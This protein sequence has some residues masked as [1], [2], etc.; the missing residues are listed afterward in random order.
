MEIIG[1]L[2]A[3]LMGL[4]LG[5]LGGGGSILTVPILV[6]VLGIN[7]VLATAYSLF[8]VGT[9]SIIGAIRKGMEGFVHWRTAVIF[10][11]PSLIAVFLT[12]YFLVPA[13]PE[14]IFSIGGL[15]ITKNIMIMIFFALVMLVAS[16]SMLKTS[17]K[18]PEPGAAS[19][20]IPKIIA[21]G[22]IVGVITGLVGAGGGFLIVPALVILLGMPMKQAVG[23]SLVIISIKSLVGFLG[24]IGSGQEIEWN[25][26]LTFT[27]FSMAGMFIGLYLNRFISSTILKKVFGWF[28]VI[29]AI[30]I[31]LKE[32]SGR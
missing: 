8:V 2:L 27:A 17:K 29:M 5:L 23:T 7:P 1:F 10:S 9:T 15:M 30:F 20:L 19:F 18:G 16:W 21:E 3:V 4:T 22:L 24:D 12:R 32:L 31:L 11:I 26:I 13:I 28:I 6:Y 14:N 25:F